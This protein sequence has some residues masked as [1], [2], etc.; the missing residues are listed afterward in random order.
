MRTLSLIGLCLLVVFSAQAFAATTCPYAQS[1]SSKSCALAACSV[2]AAAAPDNTLTS[3][4]KAAGWTL[5]FDGKTF[6]GWGFTEPKTGGWVIENGAMY[7]TAKGG[8]YAY[9]QKRFGN[10]EFKTDFKVAEGTNSGVFFRW[11]KLGDP[12]QT[13]FEMQVLDSAGKTEMSKHDCG[14]LYDAKAPSC[15]PMKPAGEWNTCS[16][17]CLNSW[18]VVELNGK[19]V[20]SADLNNWDTPHKNPDGTPNKYGAALKDWSR[21]G[22][23]GFQAHGHPVWYKNVKIRDL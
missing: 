21:V 8:A 7:F 22:H 2:K 6:N 9:T 17:K 12:V 1:C 18:V 16:I 23:I 14:A 13:G 15:N 20:M 3:A 10:F 5:L 11:D 4:E 19:T